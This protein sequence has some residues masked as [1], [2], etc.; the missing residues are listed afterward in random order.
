MDWPWE[1]YSKWNKSELER[2]TLCDFTHLWAIK[3]EQTNKQKRIK[4]NKPKQ[5][6]RY[7]EQSSCGY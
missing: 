3:T 4:Q 5:T 6:C 7:R 1:Y 2:L